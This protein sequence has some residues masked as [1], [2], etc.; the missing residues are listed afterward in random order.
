MH[1]F[2]VGNRGGTNVGER[3]ERA[4]SRI[5]HS[6]RLLESKQAMEAPAWLRRFNWHLRGHRPT[7][8]AEFSER[9]VKDCLDQKSDILLATGLAPIT[10][11]ALEKL[12]LAGV[13]AINYLTDDPWNPSH[14]APWFM[15]ALPGYD[16]VYSPRRGN[17]PDLRAQGCQKVI[18]LPFAYDPELHFPEN[19]KPADSAMYSVE[20][21]FIG[22]ADRDRTPYCEALCEA[23]LSLALYGA[24]WK[25]Y[26]GTCSQWR[27]YADPKTMRM[28]TGGA[29][30]SLCLVRRAN[31]DGHTMRSFEVPAMGGC[32]LA[33]DTEE[34]RE[35]FGA[36][37]HAMV[38]FNSIPQMVEK[39]RWLLAHEEERKRLASAAHALITGGKNTY[40]DR[41]KTILQRTEE[42]AGRDPAAGEPGE[43]GNHHEA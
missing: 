11:S 42:M 36:E 7:R 39:A 40:A 1:L 20:I 28:A 23:G 27:G 3:F 24:Y 29:K 19:A 30:I 18:Y 25:H 16:V 17:L 15:H 21:L 4:A 32:M 5:G 26:G 10:R 6:T 34:H 33:E 35:I 38:Y 9:L 12:R 43:V 31:R 37:G 14:C 8:L 13:L 41:L 2:I 22:G